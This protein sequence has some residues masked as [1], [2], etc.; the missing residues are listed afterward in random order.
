[1][2]EFSFIS[3]WL[4]FRVIFCFRFVITRRFFSYLVF[5]RFPIFSLA[6]QGPLTHLWGMVGKFMGHRI[7][8][9]WVNIVEAGDRERRTDW[10]SPVL[11]FV[12]YWIKWGTCGTFTFS[13]LLFSVWF[14]FSFLFPSINWPLLFLLLF[15]FGFLLSSFRYLMKQ[16]LLTHPYGMVGKF[17][18]PRDNQGNG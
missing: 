10:F 16:R 2:W 3:L 13:S 18:G 1:M 7:T 4:L 12:V 11:L 5:F 15:C 9:G 8:W 17:N 14:F 6:K